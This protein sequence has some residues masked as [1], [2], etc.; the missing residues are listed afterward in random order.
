MVHSKHAVTW[1]I[2]FA[3]PQL[4]A[5]SIKNDAVE[6]YKD[7]RYPNTAL[8][9]TLAKWM[10]KKT[11]PA[12]FKV[13]DFRMNATFRLGQECKTWIHTHVQLE[14]VGLSI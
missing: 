13:G 8:F 6:V 2:Q 14:T 9:K 1:G 12:S 5:N 11:A 4:Y 3:F 7:S 10:R